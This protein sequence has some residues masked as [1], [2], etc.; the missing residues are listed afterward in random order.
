METTIDQF[1][2]TKKNH[3]FIF[4]RLR[5]SIS[6]PNMENSEMI[7]DFHLDFWVS[8]MNPSEYDA[9]TYKTYLF[10]HPLKKQRWATSK[11]P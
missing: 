11:C 7:Y 9:R 8:K 5:F 1:Q 10:H 4:E 2:L 3:F 6:R